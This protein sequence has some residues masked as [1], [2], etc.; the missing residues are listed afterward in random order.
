MQ[1][2]ELAKPVI[3]VDRGVTIRQI[4]KFDKTNQHKFEGD[5][6]Y[7]GLTVYMYKDEPG[8]YYDV[9]GN[10]VPEG[11]AKLAG[12]PIDKLAKARRRKEALL[13][14]D[15]QMRQQLAME[16]DEESR[17]LAEDGD[18]AVMSLPNGRAK[19]VDKETGASI[20]PITLPEK[21]ALLLLKE[22]T[23]AATDTK[24]AANPETPS[25]KGK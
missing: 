6:K 8:V 13:A 5:I 17:V 9:H 16:P 21:D 22:L 20:T 11:I 1:Q 2:A 12:Y 23:N 19:I 24:M 25:S 3:D 7:G 10:K 4:V 15:E 18:W 14:F